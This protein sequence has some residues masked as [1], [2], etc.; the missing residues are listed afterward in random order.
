[1]TTEQPPSPATS[2]NKVGD[3]QVQVRFRTRQQQHA[4]TDTAILVPARLRRYGLSEIINHLL[5]R[6]A[7][8][9]ESDETTLKPIPFNFLIDGKFLQTSLKTY[10]DNHGLS[11]EN[12]VELEYVEATLPPSPAAAFEHDE[13]ISSV[14]GHSSGLVLTGCFDTLGRV[15]D[16]SG[17]C[18]AVLKGHSGPIKSVSWIPESSIAERYR[19]VTGGQDAKVFGWE[20]DAEGNKSRIL[21]ECVGHTGSVEGVACS[22]DGKELA[23]VSWDGCVL[24]WNTD[25]NDV[26]EA[27]DDNGGESRK[28]RKLKSDQGADSSVIPLKRAQKRLTGH[29]GPISCV[30][31]A[32]TNSAMLVT[33]GWDHTVRAWDVEQS[34]NTV[35]RNCEKVVLG[36]DY[37]GENGLIVTGHSDGVLRLWDLRAQ[38]GQTVKL[39]LSSHTNW[40]SSVRWSSTNSYTFVSGSYDS[41]IKVWDIRST[42]PMYTLAGGDKTKEQKVFGVDWVGEYIFSGGEDALL[43][44]FAAKV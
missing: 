23:T 5:G 32:P 19:F 15:W 4:V 24:L 36:M 20:Y 18:K 27:E 21:Y 2:T 3:I 42:T 22:P 13:W 29:V 33:G 9:T 35:T 8:D 26:E 41:T 30:T 12:I 40:V 37:S 44:S 28:R 6:T 10:L 31:F 25:P 1:M 34:T 7:T 11:T 16:R 43:R 39:H 17:V 38:E 14:R